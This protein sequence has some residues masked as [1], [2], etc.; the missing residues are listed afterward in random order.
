MKLLD[1]CVKRPVFTTVMTIGLL[2]VGAVSCWYLPLRQYPQVDLPVISVVTTY[3]GASP[4]IVESRITKILE[5]ALAGIEGV[6]LVTSV[7]SDESS[8]I[9][10]T[11]KAKHDIDAAAADV[12]DR[13]G[14]VR[15][16]LPEGT[17][18]P[19]VKKSEA[20]AAAIMHLAFYSRTDSVH[21]AEL[22][23]YFKMHIETELEAIPGVA[24]VEPYGS[25]GHTMRVWLDPVKMASYRINTHDISA[26]LRQQNVHMPAGR[27]RSNDREYMI[28]TA[29]TLKTPEAF[30]NVVVSQQSNGNIVRISDIGYAEFIPEPDKQTFAYFN[31]H[32]AIAI[33]LVKKSVANPLEVKQELLELLPKLAKSLPNTYVLEIAYDRTVYVSAALS[34]VVRTFFE[35]VLFVSLVVFAFLWSWRAA[36][37]PL[38]A[39]PVSLSGTA[40]LLYMFGFSINTFTLLAVVLAI[41]LVVDDAIV[42]MEN[43]HRYLGKFTDRKKAAIVGGS[44]IAFAVIAMTLTLAAVYFP[45]T[46]ARGS[47]GKFFTE[48]AVTLAG[49]VIVSGWVAL[50]L[51]PMMCSIFLRA[52]DL[53]VEK[54]FN[55]RTSKLLSYFYVERYI[56][57]MEEYLRKSIMWAY[58]NITAFS[59]FILILV[60]AGFGL[61][62][63][64]PSELVPKEDQGIVNVG[65]LIPQGATPDFLNKYMLEVDDILAKTPDVSNRLTIVA[66]PQPAVWALLKPWSERSR[67]SVQLIDQELRDKLK[68]VAGLIAYASPGATALGGGGSN[69]QSVQFVLETTQSYNEL[70]SAA[71]LVESALRSRKILPYL[72]TDR[73]EDT[74][75]FCVNVDR[76]KAL[77]MGVTV[78]TIAET[79]DTFIA[80]RRLTDFR[81]DSEQYDVIASVPLAERRNI[82]D[83]GHIYVRG[84]PEGRFTQEVML[85]LDQLVTIDSNVVPLQINHYNQLRSVTLS[86][87]LAKNVSLGEAVSLFEQIA[88]EVLPEGVRYEFSG[89]TRQYLES[90]FV[91]L[92]VF[93][94]AIVFIYLVLAAQFESFIDP[95]VILFTVP[96]SLGGA[97]AVLWLVGGSLNVYTQVGLITLVGLITKHGILLVDFANK[98]RA[99]D[100]SLRAID[101]VCEAS[102]LRLRPILMTTAAMVLGALPLTFAVGAGAESRRQIGWVIVGGM[103][104][105]TFFTFFVVPVIYQLFSQLKERFSSAQ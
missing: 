25:S 48:F 23:D 82:D 75:E 50:T 101:A 29:A 35:A 91:M 103:C 27:V 18:D 100:Q 49:A 72:T 52:S 36:L 70:D 78:Q 67:T 3:E 44:E 26:A 104:V 46:L 51:S 39:I 13:I 76:D 73:G 21:T 14:R 61:F 81:K 63:K 99:S 68:G 85:P 90:R 95:L 83:L 66:M 38:V 37:I 19:L 69:E 20:D 60:V 94:L 86:G 10:I 59:F 53:E 87:E 42:V 84:T 34:E 80:G 102:V 65:A 71:Q 43:I 74:Q 64:L 96:L 54:S 1:F 22:Y 5:S 24:G 16:R 97:I 33:G 93:C 58:N 8:R 98:R 79:L 12:R 2:I 15:T 6:D 56:P 47:V 41:G 92:F 7:S 88:Y 55:S 40:I 62:F 57:K 77:S 4:Q 11:F 32:P 105:G 9:T 45:I 28:T 89:Q 17:R 30:N 31:G